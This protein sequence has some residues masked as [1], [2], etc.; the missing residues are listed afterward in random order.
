MDVL[1]FFRAIRDCT[2]DENGSRKN[3][4]SAIGT[5]ISEPFEKTIELI[6]LNC[7]R[8]L[9]FQDKTAIGRMTI[10]E[11]SLR[12]KAYRLKHVDELYMMHLQ[13]W[14]NNQATATKQKGKKTVPF[15]KSFEDFF[16]IAEE[17]KKILGTPPAEIE[18][19]RSLSDLF[20]KANS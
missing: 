19:S 3:A 11:Y 8:Y 1:G 6:R 18:R 2:D 7:L 20:R 17:E 9:G 10:K 4:K 15:F 5:S 12:M 13:A 16:N 14:L